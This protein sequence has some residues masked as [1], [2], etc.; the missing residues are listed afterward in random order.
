MT[1][2]NSRNRPATAA[3][4]AGK[5]KLAWLA[6]AFERLWAALH[7]PIVVLAVI[8]AI[9]LSGGLVFLAP[10]LRLPLIALAGLGLLWSMRPLLRLHWPSRREAIRRVEDVSGLAHRPISGREDRLA[11]DASPLQHTIWEEHRLRQLRALSGLRAGVP[12]S[13][14]C[15]IDPRALRVPAVLAVVAALL[16]GPG[17]PGG[18]IASSLAVS[19]GSP[20]EQVTVDAWLKPPAYTG[21]PPVLLTSPAMVERLATEPDVQV[22]VNSTL[23]LR[24]SGGEQPELSFHPL[25]GS[26]QAASELTGFKPRIKQSD[27]LFQADVKLDRPAAVTVRDGNKTLGS[28]RISLIPDAP[29]TVEITA[30]PQGDSSGMLIAPWKVSDDY[31]VTGVTADI[32][33]ADEQDEG[34]GFSDAGIFEFPP[35]KLPIRLRQSAPKEEAG[36]SKADMAEHPWAGFMVE[37]SLS[38]TDAAGNRTESEKRV[39]RLPE[40]Q[41][42]RLL[43]RALIEQRRRLILDPDEAGGVAEMLVALLAYPEGLIDRSGT[44]IAIAAALSRLRSATDRDGIDSVI[45]MLWQIA[46]DVED[47]AFAD[48]K[49]ELEALRKE[50]QKALQDGAP[51]ERIAELTRKL[52]EALDRYMQSMMEEALKRLEQDGGSQQ[53]APQEGRMVSP[54]DLQKMLDTIEK[55]AQSGANEAAQ[56]MLSE[57]ENILRNLRPGAPQQGQGQDSPLNDMLNELSDLMRQQ[58]KLMDDTQRMPQSESFDNGEPQE[59][60]QAKP[61]MDGLGDRQQGLSQTLE[62]L[63]RELGQNGMNAPRALGEAGEDMGMAEDSL[64]GRDRDGALDQQGEALAKLREG[65][66]GIAREMMQRSQGQQG[67]QGGAGEARGDD[68]DPLGRPMRSRGEDT[69]PDRD[70]LPSEQ[71]LQR[72][73][74]ILDMLRAKAGDAG[75]P[76]PERDYIERLLRGL[77]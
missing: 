39:F 12:R 38:A 9:L 50:L 56:Q 6:L 2:D 69:G 48:A 15:D 44:H 49:A 31:G 46:V 10:W 17:D 1:S 41:F 74:E 68:R 61:G 13:A 26:E 36:E 45:K 22:P 59:G 29:P 33:L 62:G 43:A 4:L 57:L 47:G 54:Q 23:T 5:I 19:P 71:A 77:Y 76:R 40:R 35:P 14:W 51:P 11:G 20:A 53:G 75:L 70:M 8:A 67:S 72:A 66:Q 60:G 55:L 28:W 34:L 42:T 65:A 16:L 37:M 30:E 25:L 58:Q 27:G 18:T 3:Q 32:Y 52:R 73:R 64:R 24:I 21:K 63:I 7:W